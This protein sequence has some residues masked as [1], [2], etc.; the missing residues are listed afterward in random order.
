MTSGILIRVSVAVLKH[1]D[2]K[3]LRKERLYF[4]LQLIF[5]HPGKSGQE[6]KAQA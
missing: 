6:L 1:H 3:S 2:Q 5:H 4:I